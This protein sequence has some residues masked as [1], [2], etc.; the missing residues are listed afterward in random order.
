MYTGSQ[1]AATLINRAPP[2]RDGRCQLTRIMFQDSGSWNP[3]QGEPFGVGEGGL[4]CSEHGGFLRLR[5]RVF[6]RPLYA[7]LRA[8]PPHKAAAADDSTSVCA[9]TWRAAPR[10]DPGLGRYPVGLEVVLAAQLIAVHLD[11][12]RTMWADGADVPMASA[13]WLTALEDTKL[14]SSR[15]NGP[16]GFR[17][18]ADR[19]LLPSLRLP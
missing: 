7:G 1:P 15:S 14:A 16:C 8:T 3:G 4:D 9:S 19:L 11:A 13:S 17:A 12:S 2:A 5:G 18:C 10:L 6:M